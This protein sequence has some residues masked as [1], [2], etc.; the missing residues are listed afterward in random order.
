MLFGP[1]SFQQ[2]AQAEMHYANLSTASWA[3]SNTTITYT[4]D[5][6]G[7]VE[8]KTTV[9]NSVVKEAVTYHYSLAGRLDKVTTDKQSGTDNIVE[10]T[11]N[12]AGI[13]VRAYSYEQQPGGGTKSS[14]KTVIY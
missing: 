3:K 10:Y 1:E 9:T 13:R 5:D 6:N 12:N 11:Y 2:V 8:T 7:S 14:E 4:Y